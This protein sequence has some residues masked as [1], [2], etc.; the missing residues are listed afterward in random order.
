VLDNLFSGC[1][2]NLVPFPD[3]EFLHGDVRNAEIVDAAMK[4][5]AVV[6]YLAASVGNKRSI[7][8]PIKWARQLE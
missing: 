7:D 2:A 6:F 4:G 3:A 8:L 5:C 1:A